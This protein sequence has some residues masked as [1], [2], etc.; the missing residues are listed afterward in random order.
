MVNLVKEYAIICLL[1]RLID[2]FQLMTTHLDVMFR[3][4]A[5]GGILAAVY[6]VDVEEIVA[7]GAG[8]CAV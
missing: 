7:V 6:N 3:V 5:P 4:S 1:K 2:V 8:F